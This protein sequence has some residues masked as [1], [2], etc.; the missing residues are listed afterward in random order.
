MTFYFCV[1]NSLSL[2]QP[3]QCLPLSVPLSFS[4]LSLYP[5]CASLCPSICPSLSP[6]P[7]PYSIPPRSSASPSLSP[8]CPFVPWINLSLSLPP[9]LSSPPSTPSVAPSLHLH[10]PPSSLFLLGLNLSLYYLVVSLSDPPFVP[11]SSLPLSHWCLGYTPPQPSLW[12]LMSRGAFEVARAGVGKLP[13]GAG[14]GSCCQG[15]NEA[16]SAPFPPRS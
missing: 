16:P 7:P 9:Y 5:R 13:K 14:G 1:S 8:L 4:P 12:L 10:P 11:P 6:F 15:P 2:P 3:L